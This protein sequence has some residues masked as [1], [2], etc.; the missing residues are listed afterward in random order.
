MRSPLPDRDGAAGSKAASR[1]RVTRFASSQPDAPI[2]R[3][4][5]NGSLSR[6]VRA[7]R[8]PHVAAVA[9]ALGLGGVAPAGGGTGGTAGTQAAAGSAW[10]LLP[11]EPL[12]QAD[13]VL[14]DK[15]ER[16]LYLLRGGQPF[17]SYRIALGLSPNGHKEREGDFRTPEGRYTIYR[18]NPQ[19]EFFLSLGISYPDEDDQARARRQGL[20]PGGA[21]MIHGLPNVL[22]RP[23]DYYR[24]ADWTDGCIA[25]SN[26]DMLEVWLLTR[27]NIPI[28]IRP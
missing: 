26:D 24:S 8:W 18:R 15:S 7:G 19:S 9:L 27:T 22:K 4:M 16:R 21:I 28:E 23:L 13:A 25:L 17:R 2:I 1:R 10:T 11:A 12:K 14:V 5:S 20:K 6:P 3:D